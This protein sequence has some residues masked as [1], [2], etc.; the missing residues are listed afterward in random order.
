MRGIEHDF[1][2]A[3]LARQ[4][5]DHV[6]RLAP[7]DLVV[8]LQAGLQPQRHGLEALD[9]GGGAQL[10]QVLSGSGKDLLR[11]V[12][13][14]PA[15]RRRLVH[16]VVGLGN[17][18]LRAG[19]AR[20]HHVPAIGGGE[21]V[22]H[23][24]RTRRA[25]PG[26]F[27]ILVGPAAIPGHPAAFEQ[28]V[29]IGL[30]IVRIVDEDDRDLPLHVDAGIVVPAEFRGVDAIADEHQFGIADVGLRRDAVTARDE[31]L[32]RREQHRFLAAGDGQARTVLPGDFHRRHVL[33]PAAVVAGLEASGL[34]LLDQ[35]GNRLV[36]TRRAGRAA[37]K[38]VGRQ[39]ADHF[40]QRLFRYRHRRDIGD[41]RGLGEGGGG[42]GQRGCGQ[43][44]QAKL[45]KVTAPTG[46]TVARRLAG[47]R[48]PRKR[49]YDE[50]LDCPTING[51]RTG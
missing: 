43:Q 13:L 37:F 17:E 30:R 28:A 9:L 42:N 3:L 46:A 51:H 1:I 14:H 2:G 16:R 32:A 36:L 24:Q 45:H 31:I 8:E 34:E 26:G 39:R 44:G 38:G 33:R 6:A 25:L 19:P 11:H 50:R 49:A 7:A 27:L 12:Q 47:P 20:F 15:I 23:D 21:G 22:M 40:L 29:F 48:G 4:H 10:V 35:V 41:R 5:A 18:I